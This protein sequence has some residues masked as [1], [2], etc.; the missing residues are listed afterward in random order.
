MESL[1]NWTRVSLFCLGAALLASSQPALAQVVNEQTGIVQLEDYSGSMSLGNDGGSWLQVDRMSG[2]GVGFQSGYT[3]VGIRNKWVDF[4]NSHI[5]TEFNGT[6]NDQKRL[7]TNL[8]LGYRTMYDGGVLGVHGWYD[9]YESNY[10]HNYQQATVGAEYLHQ[11]LDLRANGYMPFGDRDNFIGVI[12]PGTQLTCFG[13]DFGTVGVGQVERSLAGF[14]AEAGVPLPVATFLRIY[15]GT[16]FLTASGD[17]TW[18][19]RSRL[20]ARVGQGA[21]VNFMVSDDDRF[22]TNLNLN[23]TIWYGGGP[24]SPFR[25]Q[26]NRSGYSR[27]YDPVRRAQPVQLA[28]DHVAVNVPLINT[29]TGN[30]FNVTWVDNTAPA[31]GDGSAEHP[32]N[33][34]PNSAPGSDYIL[35]HRG[36]GN[37]IGNIQLEDNQHLFGEGRAYTINTD[38]LGTVLIPDECFDQT[39][40]APILAPR[41]GSENV[42]IVKLANNNEVINFHMTGGTAPAIEAL[43]PITNFRLEHLDITSDIGINIQ[44]G[45][46]IG[47]L[48]DIQVPNIAN[49]QTGITIRNQGGDRL[50][51]SMTNISTSGG[52]AGVLIDAFGA[53]I[54]GNING[55][56]IDDTSDTGL[57]LLQDSGL[58]N[59]N[60]L[61]VNIFSI[62]DGILIQSIAGESNIDLTD[63]TVR[64]TGDLIGIFGGAGTVLTVDGLNVDA[65]NSLAGSGVQI[66]VDNSDGLFRFT[67]LTA[68]NNA[69][70]GFNLTADNGSVVMAAIHDSD[71][72]SNGDNNFDVTAM[73]GSAV[74]FIVDPTTATDSG[75]E[76]YQF[77]A[78]DANTVL[79]SIF[80]DVDLARAGES[81]ISGLVTQGATSHMFLDNV[82]A[83]DSGLHGLNVSVVN[84]LVGDSSDF[85]ATITNSTFTRSGLGNNGRGVN[86]FASNNAN[87]SITMDGTPANNNG[88]EGLHYEA[89]TGANGPATINGVVT[90]GNFSDNP[91]FNVFG[92]VNGAGSTANWH[93]TNVTADL[94]SNNGSVVLASL[95]G[96]QQDFVWDGAISSISQSNN[97]GVNLTANGVGSTLNFAFSDGRI[98]SNN[99]QGID[100]LASAGGAIQVDLNAAQVILNRDEN[101]LGAAL[102]NSSV[103]VNAINSNLSQGG[104]TTNRDNVLLTATGANSIV[105]GIFDGVNLDDSGLNGLHANITAGGSLDLQFLSSDPLN[106]SSAS[107]NSNG[108]GIRIEG[109][110]ADIMSVVSSGNSIISDNLNDNVDVDV[111]TA[112]FASIQ[113]AGLM[114]R[115]LTGDGINVNF[116]A[117]GSG[118]INIGPGSASDNADDGVDI[119]VSNSTLDQGISV[120]NMTVTGNGSEPIKVVTTNSNITGGS[121][122]GNTTDGGNNGI[123]WTSDSGTVDVNITNNTVTNA[124]VNG[125]LVDLLGTAVGNDVHIDF[126]SVPG[127]GVGPLNGIRLNVRDAASLITGTI[128]GNTI[129]SAANFGVFVDVTGTGVVNDLTLDA[130]IVS[131]S[132]IDGIFYN[133]AAGTTLGN[134]VF[135]DNSSDTNG[136]N[137]L[138]LQLDSV[139]GNGT[140]EFRG[141]LVS[142]NG[143]NG[144]LMTATDTSLT[145]VDLLANDASNNGGDGIRLDLSSPGNTATLALVNGLNNIASGNVG[146][147]VNILLDNFDTTGVVPDVTLVG[148]TASNNGNEGLNL[149]ISNMGANLVS[150]TDSTFDTNGAD[151]L[152][153]SLLNNTTDTLEILRNNANGNALN[154]LHFDS[155][156]SAVTN[157]NIDGNVVSSAALAGILVELDNASS[158]AAM[159]IDGNTVTG[160]GANGI[161][162]TV[163]NASTLPTFGSGSISSNT[164]TG[165][166]AGDGINLV[167]PDTGG[168]AFGIDFDSNTITGNTGGNGVNL[169]LD[170]NA[171][172]MTATFTNNDISG[173]GN[174]GILANLVQTADLEVVNFETNVVSNNTEMGVRILTED[175]ANILLDGS[176]GGNTFDA[177]G[178]AGLGA[179]LSDDSTADIRLSNSSITNTT[180][181]AIAE[182]AG[183][184]IRVIVQDTADLAG[185]SQFD[186]NTITGNQ[187]NGV[188]LL[189]RDFGTIGGLTINN[190]T[191]DNNGVNAVRIERQESGSIGLIGDRLEI[192]GNT[193]TNE[194]EG[195][196]II[197]AN[198]DSTDFY[199]M[200]D[201]ILNNMG[202]TGVHFEVRADADIDVNMD[203]N[204]ISQAGQDGILLTEQINSASDSRGLTGIWT[205]NV[206]TNNGRHGINLSG[207][208]SGLVIGDLAALSF[209]PPLVDGNDISGNNNDGISITGPGTVTII[210]NQIQNNGSGGADDA[211]IDFHGASFNGVAIINNNISSNDGDGIQYEGDGVFGSIAFINGNNLS[212]NTGRGLNLL[213]QPSGNG[214]SDVDMTFNDNIVSNNQLEGVY[215][216]FTA[217]RNQ[218]VSASSTTALLADGNFTDSP[219]LRFNADGNQVT[220]NGASSGFSSTGFV[221]RVGTT[222]A[223]TSIVDNGGFASDGLGNFT[224]SGVIMSITNSTMGGNFGDDVYFE[225]FTSTNTPPTSAGTWGTTDDPTAITTYR[226][227][228]LARLDLTF[229]GNSFDS[230]DTTNVGAFYNNAEATFKSR[231]TTTSPP[232]GGPFPVGSDDRRRNAQ[233]QASRYATNFPSE[234]APSTD[235]VPDNYLY[236][237]M[238]NSTFRVSSGSQLGFFTLDDP[239]LVGSP[240]QVDA[241]F[242]ANGIF[243]G[244]FVPGEMPYGWGTF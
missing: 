43:N 171:G 222:Q 237:G 173:N 40:P 137:G 9:N 151:G 220:A 120:R 216:V 176:L 17:D 187:S 78:T 241:V 209:P 109:N 188:D 44:D 158:L 76:A 96:G 48:N 186:G 218:T 19:A 81:A 34:L 129:T 157:L 69:D 79:T 169:A 195:V 20:E 30:R 132:G 121:I 99:G 163:L 174:S 12:N 11:W 101:V 21:T 177:N 64:G 7:G 83:S 116:D 112:N 98:N 24:A 130:N 221:V 196:F 39:G 200:N 97:D 70:D 234:L 191:F 14:D 192:S 108:S 184:G 35:V 179:L 206:I 147:G 145:S 105:G 203:N 194:T 135:S 50:N 139:L 205:N 172:T 18:G 232:N 68:S 223:S 32:F 63:V 91:D 118:G 92:L 27:I 134:L 197:A 183:Q 201:N 113:I 146:A 62:N 217:S 13:H 114:D 73:G 156:N 22:G 243:Y 38:R 160:N 8:G 181:G 16:Y 138:N 110:N 23:A 214:V 128:N 25:F 193:V 86:L 94:V 51:L 225:S 119:F 67:N 57:V 88:A 75:A 244:G 93:F 54:I 178:N 60:M 58:L 5:F 125:I 219:R 29:D 224:R 61:D 166:T 227:D 233:R 153:V 42:A 210:G 136:A 143:A 126:N 117:V 37:T 198:T 207:A 148:T 180:A 155:D 2:N 168:A 107:N 170:A 230:T 82:Q 4:G 77:V 115:S 52:A 85:D 3:R 10:G 202:V 131:T 162:L 208:T 141:N 228:P 236:P 15:G 140:V 167:N 80:Q 55:L 242:E 204:Q 6:I 159:T 185:T 150:I 31:G 84:G 238:G 1:M 144:I 111:L 215:V 104:Q 154:G 152:L 106:P 175:T 28:Q 133:G 66:Q 56:D 33:T 161:Q 190:N 229:T 211:G 41:P 182:F 46:G 49:N 199:E 212:F 90:N 226:A 74:V 26:R 127:N 231:L 47:I 45:S 235:G 213:V 89:L 239:T 149:S 71:V 53:E 122:D 87:I 165:H 59:L 65:S 102:A 164:I 189:V 72:S 240:T 100:A 123:S 36:V 124:A 103:F 95:A 142:N